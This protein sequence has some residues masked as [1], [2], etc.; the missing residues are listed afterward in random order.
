MGRFKPREDDLDT[1]IK[2]FIPNYIPSIGE[3][4][5]FLKINR[6]D[7][8]PEELGISVLDEP[9]INGIDPPIFALQLSYKLKS[10]VPTNMHIKSIENAEKNPN[11]IQNWIDQ[12]SDL[13]KEKMS[14][15]VNY[16]K[17]MPDIESLMQIWPE[18]L[19]STLNEI[20]FPDENINMN[21]ENYSKLACNM[22]D[23]P[24]HNLNSNRSVVEA[25]HVLFTLYS[26]FK[27]NQ[28]FLKE[29]GNQSEA[30][31]VQSMKFY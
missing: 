25:L 18:R 4:D 10:K 27:E 15:S 2:P 13:H 24:I 29:G 3:V 6:P 7:N 31:N 17:S 22:L 14:S 8:L 30:D 1:K 23:I 19:E 20:N 28:H 5:A 12:I 16:S 21:I 26:E 9:T 11:K